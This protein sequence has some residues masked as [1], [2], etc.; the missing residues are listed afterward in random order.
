M[1]IADVQFVVLD[2][3]VD[4][5][6]VLDIAATPTPA[7]RCQS[8]MRPRGTPHTATSVSK[9]TTGSWRPTLRRPRIRQQ[10]R[11]IGW[12]SFAGSLS[13]GAVH[14]CHDR[15]SPTAVRAL[16]P[17]PVL[18]AVN[19]AP[20]PE[21]AVPVVVVVVPMVVV[22]VVVMAAAMMVAGLG[23]GGT[24]HPGH[25][26]G[27]GRDRHAK[28]SL[29]THGSLPAVASRT[30]AINSTTWSTQWLDALGHSG[31]G[32]ARKDPHHWS[33]RQCDPPSSMM[34]AL[35]ATLWTE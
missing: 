18:A 10:R 9:S 15:R 20:A 21:P 34:F 28:N 25:R 1:A 32:R 3:R 33:P 4:R 2:V 14:H 17:V 11:R 7:P 19:P 12:A 8:A 26:Q 16:A 13:K 35:V 5:C 24:D 22:M 27:D 30:D 23:G 29:S 6:A 31:V